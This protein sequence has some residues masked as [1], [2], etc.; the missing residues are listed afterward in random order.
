MSLGRK[1][2]MWASHGLCFTKQG[3][4]ILCISHLSIGTTALL[5][6]LT[7]TKSIWIACARGTIDNT[8]NY[9][10]QL[11]L[12]FGGV[13]SSPLT[14]NPRLSRTESYISCTTKTQFSLPIPMV[15]VG[16]F[17]N[18]R[19]THSTNQWK[20]NFIML[21]SYSPKRAIT[22]KTVWHIGRFASTSV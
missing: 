6:S 11:L 7:T 13:A 19:G 5:N 12:N 3:S 8:R 21:L 18:G 22:F 16:S 14:W 15:F 20:P 4:L 17:V 1:A 10:T 2:D 9:Y